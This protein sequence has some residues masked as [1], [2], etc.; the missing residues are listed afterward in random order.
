MDR[1]GGILHGLSHLIVH[2][3]GKKKQNR[4][5]IHRRCNAYP[6]SGVD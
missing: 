1:R 5:I 4:I 6:S 2:L 3:I